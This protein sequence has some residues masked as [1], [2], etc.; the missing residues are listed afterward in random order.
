[1]HSQTKN[2]TGKRDVLRMAKER[3]VRF[4]RLAFADVLGVSK[5]V[6][7]PLS[8][9]EAA[10]DG[11]VTF[12]GGSIDGFV[13]GEEL[14]MILQ[15]DP[16]TFALY[17]WG[18]QARLLCDIAMPDGSPFEGCPRT[19]LKRA[20]EACRTLLPD[21]AVAIEV[22]FYLFEARETEYGSTRTSDV[23]SYFDFSAN[24][25][26]EDARSA[27][28]SA[29]QA[30]GVAVASAH[31]E[32][33]PGQHE[34]DF[35][36]TGVLEAADALLTLRTIAK[37]VAAGYGLE[38]TFMPKPL[39]DRA[40]SGLHANFRVGEDEKLYAIGGLLE[41]APALTAVCNST[42]N[43]Y[44]RLV[45]AWDAPI[46]T[47]WSERSANALVRVPPHEVPPQVEMR[48][49]DPACN[50]YLALAVLTG[51]LADGVQRQTLP[52]DPLVGS[53]YDLTERD[54]RERGI[55]TLPKSLRQ[56]IAELDADGVVRASLGDHVYHAFRDAKLAEYE[57][58]RRA[59]HPWEHRAYLRL[60]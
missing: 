46:Y 45:A 23:G 35:P 47:V 57:R 60:Y 13:R 16:A 10:L 17:P 3:D 12:D 53:T 30:M 11:K 44:K 41:H 40:G 6:S 51:A 59:V 22:E 39:E 8:E 42:V 28:V 20:G 38:A 31:H 9:L 32:H 43:S 50:P 29:L 54:R 36:H 7:I 26:G 27:I 24:D 52:G 5:N 49:P 48:S 34:I 37:H 55:G 18:S 15:P 56:A 58:Y 33:G 25:R 21:L 14:D 1:M 2:A 4:V 19:A